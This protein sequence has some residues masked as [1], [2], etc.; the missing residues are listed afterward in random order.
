MKTIQRGSDVIITVNKA[1]LNLLD[2][3][4]CGQCFRFTATADGGIE[5]IAMGR[6]I[7]MSQT[8]TEVTI[9]DTTVEEYHAIWERY[10]GMDVDYASI[11]QSLVFDE[12]IAKAMEVAGGIRILKQ[13]S[14]EALCSFLIS[15]NNNIPRI[16]GSVRKLS[17]RFGNK[18]GEDMYTFPTVEQLACARKEDLQGL[19]L[20]YRDDYI[21]DC[22]ARITGGELSL[23]QVA[24]AEIDE[25]RTMLRAIKGVGPKVCE[26][27]LLFGFHRLEAFP[28][29]TWI[30]KVLEMYYPNGFPA[31]AAQYAGVAQQYLFHYQRQ[32]DNAVSR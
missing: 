13:D 12:M 31:A 6:L 10:L 19:S 27:V 22:V 3:L 17:E 1:D 16:K 2:T 20:G 26:C 14:F 9:Y 23:S 8:D 28:I 24:T 15:Q 7:H 32:L 4:D 25:A 30:K 21:L 18:L 5:G 11:K 29:D